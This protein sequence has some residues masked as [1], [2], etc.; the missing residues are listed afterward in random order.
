M[1]VFVNLGLESELPEHGVAPHWSQLNPYGGG[2][3]FTPLQR[4]GGLNLEGAKPEE[5]R[6]NPNKNTVTEALGCYP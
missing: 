5:D 3:E 1:V 2:P 4:L 6:I